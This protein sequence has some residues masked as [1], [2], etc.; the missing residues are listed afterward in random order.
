MGFCKCNCG[1]EIPVRNSH[2]CLA[3]F[4][5]HH[6]FKQTGT[7]HHNY[8]NGRSKRA[9]IYPCI[10]VPD[11]YKADKSGRVYE[12]IYNYEQY[13]KCCLLPW[14]NINHIEHVTE[15]YCNNMPWNLVAM[16]KGSHSSITNIIDHSE[17][18]CFYCKSNKTYIR[19][20]RN[21]RP[22]WRQ[23][24]NG[25]YMCTKCKDKGKDLFL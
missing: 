1:E 3:Q 10:N 20:N 16:M 8:K 23:D 12:H 7:L 14:S 25:N 11:Y 5:T 4:K 17:T 2:K 24:K 15:D 19:K 21:N 18:I 6:N 22:E 13:H 9:D